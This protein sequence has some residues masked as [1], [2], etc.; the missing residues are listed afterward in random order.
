MRGSC[1]ASARLACGLSAGAGKLVGATAR[2][3][4]DGSWLTKLFHGRRAFAPA[5]ADDRDGQILSRL[6][7]GQLD[8][9]WEAE[10]SGRF[11]RG[12]GPVRIVTA[13]GR[14]AALWWPWPE[15]EHQRRL[16]VFQL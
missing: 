2:G 10:H 16:R 14:L 9:D 13:D 5:R 3:A 6:R 11:S 1:H 8:A 15:S 4:S 12:G 7:Y